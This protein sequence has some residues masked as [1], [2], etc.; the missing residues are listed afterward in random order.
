MDICRPKAKA[1]SSH[2]DSDGVVSIP[3]SPD[4]LHV[5]LLLC[6]ERFNEASLPGH[7]Y[8]IQTN[9]FNFSVQIIMDFVKFFREKGCSK[10]T[11]FVHVTSCF[12][13]V[14]QVIAMAINADLN[15]AAKQLP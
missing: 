4:A 14:F 9:S 13:N 3:A 8:I 11:M 1:V 12:M 5:P 6:Q 10:Q 15:K 2:S 7:M